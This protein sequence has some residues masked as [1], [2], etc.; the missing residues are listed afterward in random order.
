MELAG[1][2]YTR[3]DWRSFLA[4]RRGTV[5]VALA[6]GIV[7]AGILI[8][9]MARY[10]HSVNAEGKQETVLVATGVIQKGT[11]GAAI[12]SEQLFKPASVVAKQV[13]AGSIVDTA[14]LQGKV[15]AQEIEPGQQ[16]TAAEFTTTS[17]LVGQLAPAQRAIT[18]P[19]D[20]SHG[21]VGQIHTGDHVDVY[22]S[23]DLE[24][25]NGGRNH[26]VLRLLMSD[27]QVLKAGGESSGG[28]ASSQTTSVT[29]NV[30]DA[31]AG[32]LAFASDNGKVWLVLRP[33]NTAANP[34]A[35]VITV[36]TLLLGS[37]AI[38]TGGGK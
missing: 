25:L 3:N 28:L 15:A 5:L 11:S 26:P 13:S 12:A 2:N 16:L 38:P 33:A 35:P 37:T 8:F 29:L 14:Q 23:F 9:A 30:N 1:R 24:P 6:C 34:P 10:R 4:T 19:V 32:P 36:E 27:I 21:M 31:R 7:A 20:T 17:G 22:A 18:I